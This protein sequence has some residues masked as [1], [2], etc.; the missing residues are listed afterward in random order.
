ME[1]LQV[2]E[3]AEL[4]DYLFKALAHY[5]KTKVR[6]M[7]KFGS[8]RVNGRV[9]T[10]HRHALKPGDVIDFLGEKAASVERM[11]ERQQYK[12]VYE[13]HDIIVTEKPA[14][15][16]TMGTEKEKEKTLYFML[17][18]YLRATT[19]NKKARILI[20]H[21]L[22]RDTSGYVV[23]AKTET[24]KRKLQAQWT[25]AVKKYYAITE[26]TP[27]PME[28]VLESELVEDKFKRVYSVPKHTRFSRTAVTRYQVMRGNEFYALLEITLETGRKNQIRVQFSDAGH[29]LAGDEKYGARTN[30]IGRLALHA[31]F[32]SIPHPATGKM[33]SFGPTLPQIFDQ[34]IKGQIK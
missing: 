6:Q 16:L 28:G 18:E 2:K 11:K 34:L 15:L 1:K 14:G 21:R 24:A 19:D 29:P 7:L 26:G 27:L 22:D 8:V 17:T 23:F 10:L 30:P 31:G 4:L 9:V 12:I 25:D 5:K 3:R 20:V 13:D 33:M 32:L